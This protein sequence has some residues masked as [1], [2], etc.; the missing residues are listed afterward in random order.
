MTKNDTQ[1]IAELLQG[2]YPSEKLFVSDMAS[3]LYL[4]IGEFEYQVAKRA[5]VEW[6]KSDTREIASMP[7]PGVI[8]EAVNTTT[9]L[10][11]GIKKI[12][13]EERG[14]DELSDLAKGLVDREQYNKLLLMSE[15]ELENTK[16]SDIA[17]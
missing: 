2:F 16:L 4:L 14:Y 13:K 1:K 12:A 3:A 5:I 15:K 11:V 6:V 8:Y 7:A 10:Y 17:K 9:A